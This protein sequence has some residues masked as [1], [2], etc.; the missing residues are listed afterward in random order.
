MIHNYP[1]KLVKKIESLQRYNIGR[2]KKYLLLNMP[3]LRE[4]CGKK[5]I[6]G[7]YVKLEEVMGIILEFANDK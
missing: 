3:P 4:K 1:K 2:P 7:E 5:D 6:Y